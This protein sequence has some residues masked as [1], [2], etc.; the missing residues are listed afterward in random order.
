M[1]ARDRI[2]LAADLLAKRATKVPGA[3]VGAPQAPEVEVVAEPT[4]TADLDSAIDAGLTDQMSVIEILQ[5]QLSTA[6]AGPLAVIGNEDLTAVLTESG[7]DGDNQA[8]A[9]SPGL[10]D[11]E[12]FAAAAFTGQM[13]VLDIMNMVLEQEPASPSEQPTGGQV[14]LAMAID[15]N[16][17]EPLSSSNSGDAAVEILEGGTGNG[18]SEEEQIDA[19]VEVLITGQST[20]D[21]VEGALEEETGVTIQDLIAQALAA[22]QA[23]AAAND[24]D[25]AAQQLA[26]VDEHAPPPPEEEEE[27]EE[28]EVVISMPYMGGGPLGH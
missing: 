4:P 7:A 3:S 18:L 23:I 17:E 9:G 8:V 2:S 13:S 10:L 12:A 14:A 11:G 21:A 28:P 15:E 25:T 22:A 1:S 26:A 19:A 6:D 16:V 27:D 20:S 5:Q 24:D